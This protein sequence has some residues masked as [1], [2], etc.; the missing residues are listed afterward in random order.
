MDLETASQK[1]FGAHSGLDSALG[2][3]PVTV[4][5]GPKVCGDTIGL[6]AVGKLGGV[7]L[8]G[9]AALGSAP[10]PQDHAFDSR[11]EPYNV[12]KKVFKACFPKAWPLKRLENRAS[13]WTLGGTK[14]RP[15]RRRISTRP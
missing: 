3:R 14:Q 11:L 7:G 8:H 5:E 4:R 6:G 1:L 2:G 10:E 12:A 15:E 9:L 13:R